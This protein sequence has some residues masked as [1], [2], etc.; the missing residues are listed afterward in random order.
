M[1]L[2]V[3]QYEDIVS[4]LQEVPAL[5]DRLEA[6]HSGFADE[7]LEWLKKSE[8]TLENNR[9]PVVSQVSTCRATLIEAGR[10]IQSDDIVIAGRSTVRKIQEGTASLVL[11]RSSDLLHA[12]IAERQ[13]A[14]QEAERIARQ[15]LT[16][17]E[18]KGMIDAC[19]GTRSH[20]AMLSCLQEKVATDQDL[21]S[22]YLHLVALVGKTDVLIFFDR[23]LVS[24][25]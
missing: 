20:Q 18:A 10:G 1:A 11:K 21:A 9:L 17:A 16:V 6:R 15:I 7:V 2:N 13:V 19:N 4:L 12:E 23:A 14:F 22:V 5:V 3:V 25:P 24:L 8:K